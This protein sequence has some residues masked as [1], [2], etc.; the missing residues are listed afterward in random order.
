MLPHV[1]AE[2]HRTAR[3]RTA[4]AVLLAALFLAAPAASW[5]QA[6][7]DGGWV[8]KRVVQKNADFR[9]R[10]ENR[11]IDPKII[12]TYR[13][14]QVNGGWLW[15]YAPGRSGWA[16]ADEVVP[17]EEAINY[18]TE[19]IR[20]NPGA[21]HGYTMRAMIWQDERK[22]KEIALGDYNEAI[23]LDPTKAY[24]YNNRGT[25][26]SSKKEYD[27]AIADYN[28]AI[29][30]DPSEA[31]YF[32][33]RGSIWRTKKDYDKAIADLDESLRLEP[34]DPMTYLKRGTIWAG[35]KEHDKAI[36]DYNQA[37]RLDPKY[38]LAY[39]GRGNAYRAKLDYGKALADYDEAIRLDP[40]AYWAYN[41]RAWL[42]A[43][44]VEASF[45][46]G[47]RAVESAT[48]ACELAK[49]KEA[50][51]V[52][53]RA[54]AFAEAGDFDQAIKLQ[55]QANA[56]YEDPK[57]RLLGEERIKLFYGQKKPYHE[58]RPYREDD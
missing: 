49:G 21:A 34:S 22:E 56:M 6:P 29:R 24:V 11:A 30:L 45:R 31:L 41:S 50:Y 58:L 53:T 43:T 10:V 8:G 15:L 54:A 17:V 4:R 13:V 44:C 19:V 52:G 37:I 36:A 16:T 1:E 33:N 28:E 26:W 9:L 55:V 42:L 57:D 47:K 14:E 2:N 18:F 48:K 7:A 40:A 39:E 32:K 38:A 27:K 46:D 5:A 20:A 3:T 35:K 23:R 51:C 12:A 25:I